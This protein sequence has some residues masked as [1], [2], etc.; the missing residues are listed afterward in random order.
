MVDDDILLLF[1]EL[2]RSELLTA[3]VIAG[4][5]RRPRVEVVSALGRLINEGFV[6]TRIVGEAGHPVVAYIAYN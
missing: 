5:I 3:D 6:G 4:R 2:P 1:D